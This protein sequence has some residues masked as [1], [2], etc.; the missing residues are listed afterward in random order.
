M[1]FN[2]I[3]VAIGLG[4]VL[5]FST[6]ATANLM[7]FSVNEKLQKMKTELNLTDEQVDKIRPIIQDYKDAMDKAQNDKEDR[8]RQVL[9]SDQ[10]NQLK[11]MKKDM[12]D[13]MKDSRGY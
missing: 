8:L 12:K 3:K 11:D 1:K 9:S 13:K 2:F 7:S 5:L 4:L 10:M 6:S